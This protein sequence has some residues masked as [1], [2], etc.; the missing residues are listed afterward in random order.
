MRKWKNWDYRHLEAIWVKFREI[1]TWNGKCEKS[2]KGPLLRNFGLL[3]VDTTYP[4]VNLPYSLPPGQIFAT[5]LI[6]A[7]CVSAIILIS[8]QILKLRFLRQCKVFRVPQ[9]AWNQ[10]VAKIWPGGK[11]YGKLTLGYMLS[12]SNKPETL[13]SGPF[14]DIE[15]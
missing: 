14:W 6:Q 12:T 4:R 2:Q 13:R 11:L 7:R 10:K 3:E 5:F 8:H 15:V 1:S 9:S